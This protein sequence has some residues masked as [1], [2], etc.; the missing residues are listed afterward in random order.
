[1]QMLDARTRQKQVDMR[2]SKV[3]IIQREEER[4]RRGR[5]EGRKEGKNVC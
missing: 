5:K 4:K 3:F 1:M 2:T